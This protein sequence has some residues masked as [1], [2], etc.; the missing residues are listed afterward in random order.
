[1]NAPVDVLKT[2]DL[3]TG[4]T[5]EQLATIT[6]LG[7]RHTY[8]KHDLIICTGEWG[9]TFYIVLSGQVEVI[10]EEVQGTST[11]VVLGAGQGFG[12]MAV[13]D[14]GPRS[15]T[16]RCVS[17]RAEVFVIA[18]RRLL[19]LCRRESD[20]GQQ[21]M[22]NLARDLAFKLRHRNLALQSLEEGVSR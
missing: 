14:A 9:D 4:L 8:H 20:I 19:Q 18:G 13:L 6:A 3:F 22:Y 1:M 7:E 5:Q 17:E 11:L 15:A 10:S 16:I 21:L 12:E 2:A